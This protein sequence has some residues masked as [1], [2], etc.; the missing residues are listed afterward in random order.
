VTVRVLAGGEPARGVFVRAIRYDAASSTATEA[1]S[2]GRT[3]EQ[4]VATIEVDLPIAE[5]S[6]LELAHAD[7]SGA[8]HGLVPLE[9]A[10]GAGTEP[11]TVALPPG[12]SLR[13]A[14]RGLP[15][16]VR[17]S[18]AFV[19]LQAPYGAFLGLFDG[20]PAVAA[21][22]GG[23][24]ERGVLPSE[25]R[26]ALD[27]RGEGRLARVP[28]TFAVAVSVEG[29][30]EG[31]VVEDVACSVPAVPSTEGRVLRVADGS[32]CSYT[33]HWRAL[34][35]ASVR[36]V[37]E[38]GAPV[39]GAGVAV[40]TAV[41]GAVPRVS[42]DVATTDADGRAS[43]LLWSGAN[44]PTWT[45]EG[46]V[47]LATAPGRLASVTPVAGGRWYGVEATATLPRSPGGTFRVAGT[48]RWRNGTP[49]VGIPVA[50]ASRDP[51]NGHRALPPMEA[52]TAPDGGWSFEVSEDA[53]PLFAYGG[54]L[55]LHVDGDRLEDGP[56]HAAW[57]S[58]WPTLP[59]ATTDPAS[60]ELPPL[61]GTAR[62][63]LALVLPE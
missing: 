8:R 53:R 32:E 61:R 27:E 44:L 13:V 11:A 9:R 57:R 47:V 60:I 46:Y 33:L 2:L 14:V 58:K 19:R 12:G 52:V 17:A 18:R 43:V 21:S 6:W 16:G 45:P 54:G 3:G 28:D 62:A 41:S 10:L 15:E 24:V 56:A 22:D 4:G 1:S 50:L 63:D 39:A 20:A 59:R 5:G 36:V 23:P 30:P 49:A 34:P 37:D 7:G 35:A 29:V 31:F 40:G 51:W 25:F 26:V 48:L 42:G 38:T 55:R